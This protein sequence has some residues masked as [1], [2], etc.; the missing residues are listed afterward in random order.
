MPLVALTPSRLTLPRPVALLA[1]LVAFA[2]A[3]GACSSVGDEPAATVAGTDIS[4]AAL[5]DEL[6]AI[7]SNE[8][9]LLAVEQQ[10]QAPSQGE[11]EGTYDTTFVARLLS[12]RVYYELV[13]QELA[14]RDAGITQDDI[15]AIRDETIESVGGRETFDGFPD[16]YR[17]RLVR[18]RAL[19]AAI[20][21][22]FSGEG[23][24]E[25]AAEA[26]YEENEADFQSRCL[27]HIL[28]GT[29]DSGAG[30]STSEEAA[31]EAADLAAQLEGGA[32]FTELAS[33][34]VN[35]DTTSAAKGGSLDCITRQTQFDPTFLEA[36]FAAEV[37]QVTEPVETQFGFHLIL[38]SSAEVTPFG[39][40]ESQ[41]EQLL[42]Q[43]NA[44]L[45]DEFLQTATCEGDIEVSARYGS[46]DTSSC[47][48]GGIGAVVAPEG[49]TTTT[50]LVP[51]GS[52]L[53]EGTDPG[54]S[55]G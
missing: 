6:E 45:F 14:R 47:E 12:L 26:Y 46:W 19:L 55:S 50:S 8:D 27:A 22:E 51:N 7:S 21:A 49:P 24:E 53:L 25:G 31:A 13:E 35:D 52:E 3:A 33:S 43:E 39:E 36:A 32:D 15:D 54:A 5:A 40:V 38:V 17:E 9:Y 30:D 4:R 2:L 42:A 29:I 16:P 20:E 10:F 34:A 23:I 41:I 48:A 18:Q 11:G 1:A 28:V 44:G 37:G